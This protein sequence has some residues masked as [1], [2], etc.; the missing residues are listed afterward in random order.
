MEETFIAAE[1]VLRN[2][3][4]ALSSS[5]LDMG[6]LVPAFR[7]L[8]PG[9]D[10]RIGDQMGALEDIEVAVCWNPTAGQLAAMPNLRLIQ[11]IAAG[12]DHILGDPDFPRHVPVCRIIDPGMAAGMSAYVCWAVIHHQRHFDRYLAHASRRRWQG[13]AIVPPRRHRVGIAGFGWLGRACARALAAVGYDVRAWHRGGSREIP[14]GVGIYHGEDQLEQFLAGC[15]T[16]VCLLPLTAETTGFLCTAVF[17][18]LPRGAH[19]INVARGDHLVEADLLAALASGQI[20]S[21]TLDTFA[22]EPLPPDHPFWREPRITIT[23]HIASRTDLGVVARQ[24]LE[25]LSQIDQG[26]RPAAT[27]DPDRGY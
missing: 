5:A 22:R 4:I 1:A 10:I 11:S 14:S 6:F 23:P 18:K 9:A 3:C 27:I 26:R 24:T 20:G 7:K 13:E 19:L 21:A 15:D 12:V 16:L 2:P 17:A 8:C 25:N